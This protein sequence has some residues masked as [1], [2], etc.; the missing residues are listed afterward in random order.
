MKR[1]IWLLIITAIVVFNAG[2]YVKYAHRVEPPRV[3]QVKIDR[4]DVVDV[5]AATGILQATRTVEIGSQV[6]GVVRKLHADFNSIVHRGDVLAEI[7][8][9]L[10]EMDLESARAAEQRAEVDLEQDQA[11]L[12]ND[13]TNLSRAEELFKHDLSS[14][15]DRETAEVQTATD[16]LKVLQDSATVTI[17]QA[18]V[19]QAQLNVDHCTITSPI[20]GIVISREVDEGQTVTSSMTA[21]TLYV[22]ATDLTH[23]QLMGEIDESVIGKIHTGQDVAFT[24]DAYPGAVFHGQVDVMRLTS[25]TVNNVVTYDTVVSAQNPDLR[26]RPGMTASLRIEAARATGVL[27][28]PNLALRFKP[29]DRMFAAFH[30]SPD[31]G[32][33]AKQVW[34]VQNGQLQGIP[35][36]LGLTDGN[37][38][39][40]RNGDLHAGDSVVVGIFVPPGTAR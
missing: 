10:S 8:P 29:T 3:F 27:R 12:E 38:T 37:M 9:S 20:D 1:R 15:A 34:K 36:Q 25:N 5:A 18:S 28:A 13:R 33:A 14:E 31:A 4:G 40:V 35:L 2:V 11:V 21:P 16:Q 7:D 26:L 17:A 19:H 23:L 22:L 39:E 6:T 24:V 32:Q 30:Q